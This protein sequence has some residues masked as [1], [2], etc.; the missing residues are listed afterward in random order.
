MPKGLGFGLAI[1]LVIAVVLAA[2]VYVVLNSQIQELQSEKDKLANQL[3]ECRSNLFDAREE[4]EK[5]NSEKSELESR[6]M[7][8]KE[9]LNKTK[10]EYIELT[11]K[12]NGLLGSL[13]YSGMWLGIYTNESELHGFY[14]KL[15]EIAINEVKR[16]V[17]LAG[18]SG[19]AGYR[20]FDIFTKSAIWL[21]YYPDN[22]VRYVMPD[23]TVKPL[24]E[25]IMLPNETWY[26]EGGDCDDLA[27]FVYAIL[28]ATQRPGEKVYYITWEE[29]GGKVSHAGVFLAY[30]GKYYV[31]DL[32]GNYFNGMGVVLEITVIDLYGEKWYVYLSPQD[33]SYNHK[34]FLF[35]ESLAAIAYWDPEKESYVSEE[36]A[37]IYY[38]T[39]PFDAL[40]DWIIT[41]WGITD[42]ETIEVH[43]I[44]VHEKFMTIIDAAKWIEQ[45]T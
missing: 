25:V 40:R 7:V 32:A 39:D 22:Y 26:L 37:V 41:Y 44:G 45:N 27:L 36:E 19:E 6:I 34:E 9:Q 38:Y 17:D 30:D 1:G 4:I 20:A 24:Q 21:T 13:N 28:K 29:K 33:I 12:Y 15:F 10:T 18:F 2:V 43:D 31:V 23:G 11:A 3:S 5:L 14:D 8:L 16:I 42:L 35:N